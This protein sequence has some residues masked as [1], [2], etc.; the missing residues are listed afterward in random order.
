M[1]IKFLKCLFVGPDPRSGS[2]SCCEIIQTTG[3]CGACGCP[4]KGQIPAAKTGA[5]FSV[6]QAVFIPGKP[7]RS[8][9]CIYTSFNK[10]PGSLRGG[11]GS[12]S[13]LCFTRRLFG[14]MNLPL[15]RATKQAF[16]HPDSISG[17]L[18]IEWVKNDPKT[19]NGPLFMQ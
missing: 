17:L 16:A 12:A 18:Q 5:G 14:D 13:N 7:K 2:L 9:F 6:D 4:G 19:S 10:L 11:Q 1:Q 3:K 8:S 15:P